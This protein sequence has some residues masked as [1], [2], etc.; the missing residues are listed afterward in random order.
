MDKQ[1]AAW[2]ANVEKLLVR[3]DRLSGKDRESDERRRTELQSLVDA[4]GFPIFWKTSAC[5][6]DE[7]SGK[8]AITIPSLHNT[9]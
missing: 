6:L 3:A 5:L 1:L 7:I 8:K 4:E 9:W 2:K